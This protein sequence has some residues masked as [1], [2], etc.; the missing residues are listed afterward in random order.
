VPEV[1]GAPGKPLGS[2]GNLKAFVT[3]R[4]GAIVIHGCWIVQQLGQKAG[5]A[6]QQ[7][8]CG[9]RY[10]PMVEIESDGL[11]DRMR[12]AVLEHRQSIRDFCDRPGNTL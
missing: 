5:A 2:S 6:I 12:N 8:K 9:G 7:T 10:C 4:L 3:A 11:R 1:L